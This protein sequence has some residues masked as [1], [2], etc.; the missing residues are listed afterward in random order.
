MVQSA[1]VF[2]EDNG[3]AKFPRATSV[4]SFTSKDGFD[5]A[6]AALLHY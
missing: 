5:W 6:C 3:V 2:Y 4:L 1:I